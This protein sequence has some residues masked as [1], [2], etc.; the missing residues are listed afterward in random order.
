MSRLAAAL[1][2]LILLAGAFITYINSEVLDPEAAGVRAADALTGDPDLRAAIAAQ[3]SSSVPSLPIVGGLAADS[4]ETALAGPAAAAAF[5]DSVSIAVEDLTA[6]SRPDP[7]ELNL[8]QVATEAVTGLSSTPLDLATDQVDSLQIDLSKVD[9]L[10]DL[11]DFVGELEP[12]GVPLIVIGALLLLASV[13]LAAGVA[14]GLLAAALSIALASCLGIATLLVGRTLLGAGFD[15][16]VTR[17]AVLATWSAL[18]GSL[19]VIFIV[20]AISGLLVA[21]A[22]W[23]LARPAR[24]PRPPVVSSRRAPTVIRA[25]RPDSPPPPPPPSP[26]R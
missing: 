20:A 4:V 18:S 22:A 26:R 11:L 13:L 8:A 7:L 25:R 5:G 23:L 19:M 17:E 21:A 3:I 12:I 15:E 14:E 10:L 2:A 9:R 16:Q 6:P 24:R 1:G